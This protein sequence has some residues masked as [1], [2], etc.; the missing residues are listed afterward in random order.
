M[1]DTV[2]DVQ[3]IARLGEAYARIRSELG[4]VIVGQHGVLE[5]LIVTLFA[6]GHCLLVGVPGSPRR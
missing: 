5:E 2:D 1:S 4:K 6:R 3:A